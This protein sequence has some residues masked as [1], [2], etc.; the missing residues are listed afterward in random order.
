MA[1][2]SMD[3]HNLKWK[4]WEKLYSDAHTLCS[5]SQ[6]GMRPVCNPTSQNTD[7]SSSEVSALFLIG[8]FE[9]L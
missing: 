8:I 4:V 2:C 5:R 1:L 3:F 7:M 9:K 6:T